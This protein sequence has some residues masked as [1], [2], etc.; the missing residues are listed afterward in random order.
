MLR[1]T[2]LS[3]LAA[4]LALT[5]TP[6]STGKRAALY[7]AVGPVLIHYELDL[8][9]ASLVKRDSVTVP[10]SVQYAWPH[11][12]RQY[13]YV[14]WSNGSGA[15]HHGVSAFRIDPMSGALHPHGAPISLAAR[16]VHVTVDIPGTH[17]LAA[18]NE[19]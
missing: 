19:P 12:S 11:P 8:D 1:F 7:A 17:L 4:A 16:P 5:Q 13:I 14:A 3:I 6:T 9:S 10:D 18:Y 15:N 2:V